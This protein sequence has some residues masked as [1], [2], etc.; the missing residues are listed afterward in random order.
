MRKPRRS[1]PK[2]K[3][4]SERCTAIAFTIPRP[5]LVK[6]DAHVKTLNLSRSAVISALIE[7]AL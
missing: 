1:G 2:K 3:P 4:A 5:L 7:D 6:L